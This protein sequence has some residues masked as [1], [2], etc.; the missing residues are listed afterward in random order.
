[1]QFGNDARL[2]LAL[3]AIATGCLLPAQFLLARDRGN[4]D[5][6]VRV[7]PYYWF[8]NIDGQQHVDGADLHVTSDTTRPGWAGR[9][10]AGKG[11]WRGLFEI[12]RGGVAGNLEETSD[13]AARTYDFHVTTW[14]LV[15]TYEMGDP[16]TARALEVLAGIRHVSQQQVFGTDIDAATREFDA[17]WTEP[18]V[19]FRYYATV[20]GPF[21]FTVRSDIGGFGVG[22]KFTWVL[23]GEV[24]IE[25]MSHFDLTMRYRYLETEYDNGASGD[26]LYIWEEGQSQ[27]W[28][29]GAVFKW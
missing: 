19:G 23:D 21:W 14:E 11:R 18:L 20:G 17:S 3:I 8:S 10:E 15:A 16:L 1:M 9:L 4:P 27:G 12:S 13:P 26:E 7:V 6:F 5:F 25:V 29:F 2:R 22:S 24:G 28:L